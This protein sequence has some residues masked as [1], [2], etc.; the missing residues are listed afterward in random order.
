MKD[1]GISGWHYSVGKCGAEGTLHP[2]PPEWNSCHLHKFGKKRLL[3][4]KE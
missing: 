2:Q 1:S 3:S 4:A